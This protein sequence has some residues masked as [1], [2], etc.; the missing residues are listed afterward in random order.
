MEGT[1]MFASMNDS[2]LAAD[3]TATVTVITKG[4]LA[5]RQRLA[6]VHIETNALQSSGTKLLSLYS[7]VLVKC[8]GVCRCAD[9]GDIR[10]E[11]RWRRRGKVL[12]GFTG[13]PEAE[14]IRDHAYDT[15][16]IPPLAAGGRNKGRVSGRVAERGSS[17]R[18]VCKRYYNIECNVYA[19]FQVR[20]GEIADNYSSEDPK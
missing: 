3:I 8:W 13:S 9:L 1:D 6:Y 12:D 19:R 15:A 11:V 7:F 5:V 14:R 10:K 18:L 2:F 20:S 17:S 4:R 16:S